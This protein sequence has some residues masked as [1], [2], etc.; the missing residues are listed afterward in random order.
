MKMMMTKL[1]RA[2][3]VKIVTRNVCTTR[4]VTHNLP[5]KEPSQND[6]TERNVGS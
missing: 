5:H 6:C 3:A 4:R 1:R 2:H